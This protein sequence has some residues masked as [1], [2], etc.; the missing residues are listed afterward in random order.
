[1]KTS[2]LTRA[3]LY[4]SRPKT[5]ASNPFFYDW[6][7][8]RK[9]LAKANCAA[10]C[11]ITRIDFGLLLALFGL[12]VILGSPIIFISYSI[13]SSNKDS[14]YDAQVQIVFPE[15][16]IERGRDLAKALGHDEFARR[17]GPHHRKILRAKFPEADMATIDRLA[18]TLQPEPIAKYAVELGLDK[19]I[20]R[21]PE[22][23][24]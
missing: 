11:A 19:F 22:K 1:M 9:S 8:L 20:K 24:N 5:S 6:V 10:K 18:D 15:I 21:T 4:C 17:F 23:G 16:P 2:M 14:V 7:W 3:F 13:I 12:F